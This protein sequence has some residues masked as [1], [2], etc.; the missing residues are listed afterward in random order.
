M[1][2]QRW[3][4]T[5]PATEG[6]VDRPKWTQDDDWHWGDESLEELEFRSAIQNEASTTTLKHV[7]INAIQ[8]SQIN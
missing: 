1:R 8:D 7:A 2:Q 4:L 3:A 6:A 5:R